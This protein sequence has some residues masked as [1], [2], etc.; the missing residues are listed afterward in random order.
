LERLIEDLEER[1]HEKST[2]Q[3]ILFISNGEINVKNSL[4]DIATFMYL[5]LSLIFISV[6]GLRSIYL[7]WNAGFILVSLGILGFVTLFRVWDMYKARVMVV[8]ISDTEFK[9]LKKEHDE[10]S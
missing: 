10:T 1:K 7:G 6:E 9:K 4:K 8:V 5:V 3:T 2:W